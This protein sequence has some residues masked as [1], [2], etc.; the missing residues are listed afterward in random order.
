[1]QFIRIAVHIGILYM[2]YAIGTWI[3]HTFGLFIPGSV[4]GMISFTIIIP[5]D[6]RRCDQLFGLI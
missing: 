6:Y 3:Q 4:L 2:F 1:M 5:T